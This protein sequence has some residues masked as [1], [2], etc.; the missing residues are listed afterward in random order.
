MTVPSVRR[1]D[2]FIG[3]KDEIPLG[4]AMGFIPGECWRRQVCYQSFWTQ[5][6]RNL[7][8]AIKR[9]ARKYES[10]SS[11][12]SGGVYCGVSLQPIQF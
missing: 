6:Y 12:I 7:K 5:A 9:F 8:L 11:P 4:M 3:E 2:C 1:I 10:Q